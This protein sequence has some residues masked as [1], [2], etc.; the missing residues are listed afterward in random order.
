MKVMVKLNGLCFFADSTHE[1]FC[2]M[3]L[4][5]EAGSGKDEAP[6]D[7]DTSQVLVSADELTAEFDTLKAALLSQD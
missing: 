6:S 7:D 4:S 2:T 5:D 3:A 1:G